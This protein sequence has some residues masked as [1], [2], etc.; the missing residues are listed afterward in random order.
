MNQMD[1]SILSLLLLIAIV[2]LVFRFCPR[3]NPV[4]INIPLHELLQPRR[5]ISGRLVPKISQSQ[6][7]IRVRVWH[8]PISRHR[9]HVLLRLRV[10]QPFQYRHQSPHRHRRRVPQIVH[11]QLCRSLLLPPAPRALL[12]RVQRSQASLHHVVDEREV[13]RHL[14]R[15]LR[16]VDVNRLPLQYVLREEE[17]R[18]VGSSPWSVHGEESQSRQGEAVNVVV[19][20]YDEDLVLG[21]KRLS[22][23]LE[24]GI[25]V[26]VEVIE[27]EDTVAALLEG[28]RAMSTDKAGGAGDE[29][30]HAVG[31]AGGGGM[32]DLLLPGGAGAVE[33]GGEEVVVGV[34]MVGI[35]RKGR[36]IEGKEEDEDK[37]NEK[38]STE[39]KLRG[40]IEKLS[41]VKPPKIAVVTL[42]FNG[43]ASVWRGT[44]ILWWMVDDG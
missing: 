32:A 43:L 3:L 7:H 23:S 44:H 22:G 11:P 38:S 29:D 9:Y 25:V 27:A 41:A 17:V 2:D 28:E 33:G 39:E 21:K 36:V 20:F 13:T 42:Y 26:V 16:L 12:R 30:G 35:I 5:Q 6:A 15:L 37:S 4:I 10:Q 34:D 31:A 24:G 18:H 1:R 19:A 8:I 14:L 40:S